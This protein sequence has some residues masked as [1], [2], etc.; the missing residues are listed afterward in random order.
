MMLRRRRTRRV[1]GKRRNSPLR[2]KMNSNQLQFVKS[3][4]KQLKHDDG[5]VGVQGEKPSSPL[6]KV[7]S[8]MMRTPTYKKKAPAPLLTFDLIKNR[9]DDDDAAD[10]NGIAL[11]TNGSFD[12]GSPSIWL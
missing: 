4:N 6:R 3:L 2:K 8:N 10:D 9:E 1:R 11:N 5:V 12:N 7:R